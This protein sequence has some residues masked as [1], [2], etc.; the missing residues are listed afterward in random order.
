MRPIP[1][2]RGLR[3]NFI[4]YFNPPIIGLKTETM[5]LFRYTFMMDG[6]T[7]YTCYCNKEREG[8]ADTLNKHGLTY[9]L[10]IYDYVSRKTTIT[11]N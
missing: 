8:L 3:C 10:H 7:V 2:Y 9:E 11:Q 1:A 6:V 4:Y 5:Q